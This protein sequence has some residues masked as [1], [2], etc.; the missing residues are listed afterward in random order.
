MQSMTTFTQYCLGVAGEN[1][2]REGDY[3]RQEVIIHNRVTL[4][5]HEHRKRENNRLANWEKLTY[6]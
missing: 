3:E 1:Q 5:I 2:N 4:E 6:L